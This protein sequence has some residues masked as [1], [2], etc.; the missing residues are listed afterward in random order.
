MTDR[1]TLAN[2]LHCIFT[3]ERFHDKRN[4][5]IQECNITK[6]MLLWQILF[7]TDIRDKELLEERVYH[8]GSLLQQKDAFGRELFVCLVTLLDLL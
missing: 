3:E 4:L 6:L 8:Y 7:E 1:Y 5:I 2:Y